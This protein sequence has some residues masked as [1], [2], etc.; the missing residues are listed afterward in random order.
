ML[1]KLLREYSK[2]K[3]IN[4]P[5]QYDEPKKTKL[6]EFD[7][8]FGK[9]NA[10]NFDE[11]ND[12]TYEDVLKNQFYLF[13]ETKINF[14][15]RLAPIFDVR[16]KIINFA[17]DDALLDF[18]NFIANPLLFDGVKEKYIKI[19][20]GDI[21]FSNHKDKDKRISLS[22]MFDFM[23]ESR[24]KKP[25]V[26]VSKKY[27]KDLLEYCFKNLIKKDFIA[28]YNLGFNIVLEK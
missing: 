5:S 14:I 18:D 15:I 22:L 27:G 26:F 19:F 16:K 6:K 7:I 28:V 21:Y 17:G 8:A 20:D 11:L 3:L 12:I 23:S 2:V 13:P 4:L 1:T 9:I 25:F 24:M 10:D